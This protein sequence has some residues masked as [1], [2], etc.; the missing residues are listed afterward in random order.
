LNAATLNPVWDEIIPKKPLMD[1][2]RKRILLDLFAAPLTVIPTTIGASLI[3]MSGI[4]GGDT[5][6]YGIVGLLVGAGSLLTNFVFNL[7][8]ISQTASNKWLEEQQELKEQALNEL[9]AKLVQTSDPHDEKIL[10]NL[11]VI[12]SKF[13]VDLKNHESISIPVDMLSTIDKLFQSCILKIEQSLELWEMAQTVTGKIQTRIINNRKS[14]LEEVEQSLLD[15]SETISGV[16]AIHRRTKN[17]DLDRLRQQ[18][19]TQLQ[20]AKTTEERMQELNQEFTST[21]FREYEELAE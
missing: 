11:R 8:K 19:K 12:Y 13:C 6:F 17:A 2:L 18:M 15:L 5:A 14:I 10:R 21:R 9:D 4:F 7:D 16:W 3:M 1:S 20:V